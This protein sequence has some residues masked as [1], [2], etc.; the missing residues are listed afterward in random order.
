MSFLSEFKSVYNETINFR[1]DKDA[2]RKIVDFL[3]WI[4]FICVCIILFLQ[5]WNFYKNIP[6]ESVPLLPIH[7]RN[8]LDKYT[9]GLFITL[10]IYYI[11]GKFFVRQIVILISG[12]SPSKFMP[13]FD[14]FEDTFEIGIMLIITMKLMDNLIR[15]AHGI[16][17]TRIFDQKL[18]FA[19]LLYCVILFLEWLYIKNSN[20]WYY[21]EI[22]YTPYFD[23][24]GNRISKDDN[25]IYFGELCKIY[26][27]KNLD[28]CQERKWYLINDGIGIIQKKVLLEEAVK[29][30]DG[31]IR[32]HEY[33]MGEKGKDRKNTQ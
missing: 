11:I 22:S 4:S 25:V 31:K 29:N 3:K 9:F 5:Y 7:L 14:T 19:Y 12:K 6:L 28:T 10:I 13:L 33:G 17:I 26:L 27:E 2:A 15:F 30:P 21:S 23:S 18:Y 32:V 20:Y 8:F 16:N 1:R 24:L